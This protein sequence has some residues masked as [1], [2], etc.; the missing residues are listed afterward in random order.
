MIQERVDEE[1]DLVAVNNSMASGKMLG[2][3][4]LPKNLRV[5]STRLPK[6]NYN[7]NESS[8]ENEEVQQEK[9]KIVPNKSKVLS[10]IKELSSIESSEPPPVVH[11]ILKNSSDVNEGHKLHNKCTELRQKS[12]PRIPLQYKIP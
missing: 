10:R 6:P 2:T 11:S 7:K 8:F 1:A 9:P 3:I 5:L 4:I 12:Q